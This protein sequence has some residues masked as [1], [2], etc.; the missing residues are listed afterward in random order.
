M[1]FEEGEIPGRGTDP[2]NAISQSFGSPVP[3]W[4]EN[5]RSELAGKNFVRW[6]A[7]A[8]RLSMRCEPCGWHLTYFV[9][10]GRY[11]LSLLVAEQKEWF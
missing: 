1:D 9:D 6:L 10:P 11:E 4:Q 7:K 8:I 2:T 3:S 5:F